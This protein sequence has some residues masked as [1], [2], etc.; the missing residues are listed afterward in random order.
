MVGDICDSEYSGEFG[1]PNRLKTKQIKKKQLYD[2]NIY[3]LSKNTM[4]NFRLTHPSH[5]VRLMFPPVV[6]VQLKSTLNEKLKHAAF[7]F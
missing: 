4:R 3:T 5:S 7:L 6:V 2:I 1:Y